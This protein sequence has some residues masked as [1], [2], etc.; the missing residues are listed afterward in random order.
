[1]CH[2]ANKKKDFFFYNGLVVIMSHHCHLNLSGPSYSPAIIYNIDIPLYI[3]DR[4][5]R[6]I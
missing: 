3:F 2:N 4:Y 5:I 1:M 6:V